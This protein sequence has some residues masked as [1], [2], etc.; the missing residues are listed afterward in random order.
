MI[1]WCFPPNNY[2]IAPGANDGAIDAF[3]GARL[4]SVVREIIQNSLDVRKNDEDPVKISFS[5][6][7]VRAEEFDGFDSIGPHLSAC[8]DTAKRQKLDEVVKFYERGIKAV[9]DSKNVNV[10]CIHD[11]N[12]SGL[13][14]PI[15]GETGSWFALTK[16]AGLSQKF[17]SGSLGSFGH[18]SKA[19]FTYSSTRTVFYYS[20]IKNGRGFE[21]RFQGKSIL[22]SHEDPNS[23]GVKTQAT[24]FYGRV[25]KLQPLL[26]GDVPGW[27]RNLREKITEDT[28]TSIYV[29]YTDYK[30]DLYPETRITVV[31]NFYYAIMSGALEVA[32]GEDLITKENLIDWFRDCENILEQEQDEI[33]VP[34]I[35][36]CFKSINTIL[37][38]THQNEQ[39]VPGFGMVSWFM[40][41]GDELEKRV[42]LARSSGMLITRRPPDLLV[43]RNVKPFDMFVCVNGQEGSEFLKR[44]ENPTHDNFEFD[45]I[46]IPDERK[47][48]KKKYSSFQRR[49]RALINQ[50]AELDNQ[51]EEEV[52][53]L[54]FVFS[55]VSDVQSDV[56]AKLERGDKLVIRDGAFRRSS[57]NQTDGKKSKKQGEEDTFGS[58]LQGGEK[59][60]QNKGGSIE[61]I[62][63]NSPTKGGAADGDK[64]KGVS[65]SADN[66]RVVHSVSKKRQAKLF[67]DSP[68]TGTC[69]FSVSIIGETG[70]EPVKFIS[71]GK[72]VSWL[73]VNLKQSQRYNIEVEFE[74]PVNDMALQAT[75]EEQETVE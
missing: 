66:F 52:S 62:T 58:G 4:S 37:Q 36:D 57:K 65:Y 64:P 8:A 24:G 50:Y 30:P 55:D 69:S 18:G 49:I 61:N 5:V 25:D 47:Q 43:F 38:P 11:Y 2:G 27:A 19:P 40:R 54:G 42:G 35:E 17:S 72:V 33:D 67:F 7:T 48:F 26:N 45:R 28:G 6:E 14:G 68:L 22:Q 46:R 41:V 53:D 75:L 12:T 63:G 74:T 3:A 71:D 51:D 13:T 15:D 29:P 70:A 60:K 59:K 16:G 32:V 44:L 56:G 1:S 10:L 23:K 20:R 9:N 73:E 21:D 34:H 31:A 39:E